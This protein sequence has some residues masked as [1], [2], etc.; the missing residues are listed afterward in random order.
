MSNELACGRRL[1]VFN[2]VDDDT[3]ECILQNVDFS[4]SGQR[5]ANALNRRARR[6]RVPK[7]LFCDHGPDLTCKA[8]FFWSRRTQ[9][10]LHYIHPGKPTQRVHRK[11]QRQVP[12]VLPRSELVRQSR[13][14]TRDHRPKAYVFQSRQAALLVGQAARAMDD[15]IDKKR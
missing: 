4:I 9:V 8:M 11:L 1:R 13:R 6:R 10:K 2:L 14:C 15:L 3:R 5:L 12:R 7:T